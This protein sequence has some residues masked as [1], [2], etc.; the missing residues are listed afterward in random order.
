MFISAYIKKENGNAYEKSKFQPTIH[1]KE[2]G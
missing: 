1:A 2:K